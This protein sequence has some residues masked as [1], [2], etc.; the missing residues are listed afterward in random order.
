[1]K[2]NVGFADKIFRVVLAV[3]IALLYYFDV[4]G[5]TLGLV[6]VILAI[7][8]LLTSLLNFCPLYRI[9]GCNTCKIKE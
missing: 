5:G 3:V 7:I 2:K 1:M 9:F 4:V 6:F 8:L